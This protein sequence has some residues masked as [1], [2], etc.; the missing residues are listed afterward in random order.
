MKNRRVE[1][2]GAAERSPR[3]VFL[4]TIGSRERGAWN[5]EPATHQLSHAPP[6]ERAP[7]GAWAGRRRKLLSDIILRSFD[8]GVSPVAS[9]V[10]LVPRHTSGVAPLGIMRRWVS[11]VGV[12]ASA[13]AF[14][15]V[16]ALAG[17]LPSWLAQHVG[18]GRAL[19]DPPEAAT[20]PRGIVAVVHNPAALARV[21]FFLSRSCRIGLFSWGF[22][23][24][25][26]PSWL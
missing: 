3:F 23:S 11:A 1:T 2:G 20:N 15:G 7:R 8:G 9:W 13:G 26:E 18:C 6:S 12:P 4:D 25:A 14:V 24:R 16:P 19:R 17:A 22:A 21:F 10:T 5:R